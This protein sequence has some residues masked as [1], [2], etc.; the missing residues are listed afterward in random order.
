MLRASSTLV[1]LFE[2]SPAFNLLGARGLHRARHQPR[3][4]LSLLSYLT[5]NPEATS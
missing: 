5:N 4:V 3:R 2:S 1:E